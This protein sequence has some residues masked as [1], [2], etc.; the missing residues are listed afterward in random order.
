VGEEWLLRWLRIAQ[1]NLALDQ[2]HSNFPPAESYVK[3]G[4]S[5]KE[6]PRLRDCAKQGAFILQKHPACGGQ[7]FCKRPRH[8]YAGYLI[9]NQGTV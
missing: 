3:V 8:R 7:P 6:D 1:N 4:K 9:G 5:L 2:H